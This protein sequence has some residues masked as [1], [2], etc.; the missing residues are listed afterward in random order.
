MTVATVEEQLRGIYHTLKNEMNVHVVDY[1][2]ELGGSFIQSWHQQGNVVGFEF[3]SANNEGMFKAPA[4]YYKNYPNGLSAWEHTKFLGYRTGVWSSG[5]IDPR[6]RP[7]H[8]PSM[9]STGNTSKYTTNPASYFRYKD[10]RSRMEIQSMVAPQYITHDRP[11]IWVSYLTAVGLY[12]SNS[13]R[14]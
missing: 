4:F 1:S 10:N 2:P 8:D 7:G 11:D 12:N 3:D 14:P 13:K 5:P 9:W 6:G